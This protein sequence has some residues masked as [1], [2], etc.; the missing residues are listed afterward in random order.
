MAQAAGSGIRTTLSV[1]GASG[2]VAMLRR[3]RSATGDRS[4]AAYELN[5][6]WGIVTLN[7]VT[8]NFRSEGALTGT[9][10]AKLSPWTIASRRKGSSRVLQDTGG[11]S[12]SFTIQASNDQVAV[13][14]AMDIAK[15]HQS[16]TGT[17]GPTGKPYII[18]PVN[19]Q[20]L[21]FNAPSNVQGGNIGRVK[22][23]FSSLNSQKT[24]K[25]GQRLLFT[26]EVIHPGVPARPMLPTKE[27]ILPSL[28][29]VARNFMDELRRG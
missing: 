10:W 13:G 9:P 11:L 26:R 24:F 19:A 18:R 7:W 16:G 15:Y 20:A 22:A 17:F 29:T 27:Q 12:R 14:T 5:Y 8:R 3:L 2:V 1:R 25:K 21:A 6:R 28:L 23:A 4:Q